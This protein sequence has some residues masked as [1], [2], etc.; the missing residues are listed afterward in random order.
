MCDGLLVR[1]MQIYFV[2]FYTVADTVDSSTDSCFR[3]CNTTVWRSEPRRLQL[4]LV[5]PAIFSRNFVA[6]V[7]RDKIASL[8]WRVTWVFDSRSILC[9]SVDR[10]PNADWSVVIVVFVLLLFAV[11]IRLFCLICF[12]LFNLF[13]LEMEWS[14]V[15][16]CKLVITISSSESLEAMFMRQSRSVQFYRATLLHTRTTKL[17][18]KIA[19]VTSLLLRSRSERHREWRRDEEW[20]CGVKPAWLSPRN[21]LVKNNG[22]N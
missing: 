13:N 9:N 5:S 6:R 2:L 1:T 16:K 10:M 15:S 4:R 22:V 7:F 17:R 8:T 11:H 19:G 21:G 18:E 12:N 20:T 14:D 3:L